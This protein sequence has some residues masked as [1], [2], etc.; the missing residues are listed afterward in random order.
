MR[1]EPPSH[2]IKQNIGVFFSHI[3]RESLIGLGEAGGSIRQSAQPDKSF[4]PTIMIDPMHCS[5]RLNV[6]H[7]SPPKFSMRKF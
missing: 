1:Q 6:C 2:H 4:V 5:A 3:R 7:N